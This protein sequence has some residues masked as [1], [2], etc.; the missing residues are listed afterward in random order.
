MQQFFLDFTAPLAA[1]PFCWPSSPKCRPCLHG[2]VS[3]E[4][5]FE[6]LVRINAQYVEDTSVLPRVSQ[7]PALYEVAT[8]T[9]DDTSEFRLVKVQVI[10]LF[11]F[12]V[13][14]TPPSFM[15]D[16]D[17][18]NNAASQ[19][20]TVRMPEMDL[21]EDVISK[22]ETAH[23][24][25]V[26]CAT[27]PPPILVESQVQSAPEQDDNEATIASVVMY[28]PSP[29]RRQCSFRWPKHL[30]T[31]KPLLAYAAVVR[32]RCGLWQR[33]R[34]NKKVVVDAICVCRAL[35]QRLSRL[36][37][38]DAVMAAGDVDQSSLEKYPLNFDATEKGVELDNED[39]SEDPMSI[40]SLVIQQLKD[41]AERISAV[42]DQL[43]QNEGKNLHLPCHFLT[44]GYTFPRFYFRLSFPTA[45]FKAVSR[46]EISLT[47]KNLCLYFFRFMSFLVIS[48]EIPP[49]SGFV[50]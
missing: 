6:E 10:A 36:H 33:L 17:A 40:L 24:V 2:G 15:L 26:A 25:D 19:A 22:E 16:A 9:D 28:S 12:G 3:G 4:S 43:K 34:Q 8:S 32:A 13:W 46:V 42:F 5:S 18:D 48:V 29:P 35:Q 38:P 47:L 21:S 45:W 23:A 1:E 11:E 39:S 44:F 49:L 14:D 20:S 31:P 50:W 30:V 41:E 7:M 27:S 37:V